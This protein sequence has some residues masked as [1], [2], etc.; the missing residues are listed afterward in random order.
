MPWSG[1]WSSVSNDASRTALTLSL[2]TSLITTLLTL[3]FGTPL[4]WVL[5]NSRFRGRTVVRSVLVLPMVLP[6]VV[7]GV[8][9]LYAFGR[10]GLVGGVLHDWFGVRLAFTE[11]AAVMAQFFV[12]A[13]F[14]I[15]VMEAAFEQLDARV[16][17]SARTFGAGPW[18]TFRTVTIPLVRP[19]MVAGLVL[20]WARALGEFGATITFA[21]NTPGRTQTIPLAVYSALESGDDSALALSL[22]MVAVSAVVLVALR[23]RW[24]GALRRGG[25]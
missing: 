11:T 18:Y 19:S 10:R 25:A 4:A 13:P 16:V 22:L 6:P 2:R 20:T 23:G 9:L 7:G 5:A 17:G 8:A 15:V 1:F 21:G 24:V 12:A 14:F 3:L